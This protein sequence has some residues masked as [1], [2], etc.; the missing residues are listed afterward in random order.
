MT[1]NFENLIVFRAGNIFLFINDLVVDDPVGLITCAWF[2]IR[3]S[4]TLMQVWR[5][6]AGISRCEATFVD[7]EQR[8]RVRK[9]C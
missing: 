4:V 2:W 8:K 3:V 1:L 7:L 9:M 6:S 5:I